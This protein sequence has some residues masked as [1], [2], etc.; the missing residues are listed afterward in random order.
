MN[1]K[2]Y[3]TTRTVSCDAPQLL[4]GDILMP[5][6]LLRPHCSTIENYFT[7]LVS[8]IITHTQRLGE[9]ALC[10]VEKGTARNRVYAEGGYASLPYQ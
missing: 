1:K 4:I 5:K 2:P 9:V 7:G 6:G 8:S 10:E 3:N